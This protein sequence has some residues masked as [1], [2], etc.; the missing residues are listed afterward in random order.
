MTTHES[1]RSLRL[2][3]ALRTLRVSVFGLLT[4]V[5]LFATA[6]VARAQEGPIDHLQRRTHQIVRE[7]HRVL[8]GNRRPVVRVVVPAHRRHYR[9]V[10]VYD[11]R[12]HRYY[13]R[14]YRR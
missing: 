10:R 4:A 12:H 5:M 9:R 2:P 6:G 8:I 14:T 11:R 1:P 3:G 13:Y 7:T